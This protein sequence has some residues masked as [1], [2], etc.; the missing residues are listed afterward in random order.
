MHFKIYAERQ[1]IMLKEC[2]G[3]VPTN[4]ETYYKV[5]KLEW[6]CGEDKQTYRV[7]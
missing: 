7:G 1:Y 4:V 6:C 2:K 3:G 5:T